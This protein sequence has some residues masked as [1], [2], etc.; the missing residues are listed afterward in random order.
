LV[1]PGKG[2]DVH[3]VSEESLRFWSKVDKSGECWTWLGAQTANGYGR[4]MFRG[5]RIMAH[6]IAYM[7]VLGDIPTNFQIDHLCRNRLCVNPNHLEAVTQYENILR[8]SAPSAVNAQRTV[9]I[10]GHAF[11]E[12]NTYATPDGRR[13]CRTCIRDRL[14]KSEARRS[15]PGGRTPCLA[16]PSLTA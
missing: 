10:H 14:A 13:Q 6:R 2:N 11:T 15:T 16:P 3:N 7:L 8:S 1:I 12:R 4:N 9:C 5:R